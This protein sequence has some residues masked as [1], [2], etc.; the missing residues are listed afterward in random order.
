MTDLVKQLRDNA[1]KFWPASGS[2]LSTVKTLLNE[3]A[4]EIERLRVQIEAEAEFSSSYRAEIERLQASNDRLRAALND[5]LR[6]SQVHIFQPRGHD[7]PEDRD[8]CRK[9]GSNFR[10]TQQHIASKE[11]HPGDVLRE[12]QIA[13]YKILSK[14]GDA[15]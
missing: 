15:K 6:G 1:L 12:A 8:T 10:N 13:A 11:G 3:A 9:C 4:D 2:H 14:A 7:T 5:L